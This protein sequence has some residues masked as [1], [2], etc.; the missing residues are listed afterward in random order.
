LGYGSAAHLGRVVGEDE[1]KEDVDNDADA[2]DEVVGF[3]GDEEG[4][5]EDVDEDSQEED[6]GEDP[7]D[8]RFDQLH[9][10]R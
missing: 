4:V 6:D 10:C 8:T 5:N 9:C 3:L 7:E 2:R 1:E